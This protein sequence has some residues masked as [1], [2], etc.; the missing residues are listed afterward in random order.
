MQLTTMRRGDMATQTTKFGLGDSVRD[1]ITGYTGT[2]TIIAIGLNETGY[3]VQPTQLRDG[4]MLESEYICEARL[5][6]S[7]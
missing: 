2:V 1:S 3:R 4:R 7:S 5:V 6:A